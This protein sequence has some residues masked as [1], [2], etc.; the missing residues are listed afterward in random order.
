MVLLKT[1]LPGPGSQRF[2][3]HQ[4]Q[5]RFLGCQSFQRDT[6]SCTPLESFGAKLVG[7]GFPGG[8]FIVQWLPKTSTTYLKCLGETWIYLTIIIMFV[9]GHFRCC[10]ILKYVFMFPSCNKILFSTFAPQSMR[11]KNHMASTHEPNQTFGHVHVQ[12]IPR[13]HMS[14]WRSPLLRNDTL[15]G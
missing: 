13:S 6:P 5:L 8:L 12:A 9:L 3:N 10:F 15:N 2:K 1:S 4:T 11:P 14:F 7:V